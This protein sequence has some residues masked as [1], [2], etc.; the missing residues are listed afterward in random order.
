MGHDP[1]VD[2]TQIDSL[3]QMN[4]LFLIQWVS[5][6]AASPTKD[7]RP[8]QQLNLHKQCHI[9]HIPDLIRANSCPRFP[10][11]IVAFKHQ[12]SFQELSA[13]SLATWEGTHQGPSSLRLSSIIET[14]LSCLALVLF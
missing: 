9:H 12:R 6:A 10:F 3:T 7:H 1:W 2:P 8:E 4:C 13:I 14:V 5:V 11:A